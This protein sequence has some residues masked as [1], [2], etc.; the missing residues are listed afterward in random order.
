MK[1]KSD[2]ESINELSVQ[3]WL[4]WLSNLLRHTEQVKSIW[5]YIVDQD[6]QKNM[7]DIDSNIHVLREAIKLQTEWIFY[8]FSVYDTYYARTGWC[9]NTHTWAYLYKRVGDIL[10]DEYGILSG[11]MHLLQINDI[12]RK[13]KEKNISTVHTWTI[14]WEFLWI[15]SSSVDEDNWDELKYSS[16]EIYRKDLEKAWINLINLDTL[17]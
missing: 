11:A 5:L 1:L 15:E 10:E 3:L 9:P 13:M 16:W 6:P 17:V 12:I 7:L 14:N 2:P 4:E 8:L